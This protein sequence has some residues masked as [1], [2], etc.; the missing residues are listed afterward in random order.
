M[1]GDTGEAVG[2]HIPGGQLAEA[3]LYK[4]LNVHFAGYELCRAICFQNDSF[5]Y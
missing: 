5:Q 1:N 2:G 3:H 4:D